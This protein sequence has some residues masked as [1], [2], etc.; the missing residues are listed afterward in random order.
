MTYFIY[1]QNQIGYSLKVIE[2]FNFNSS[3][4]MLTNY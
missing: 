4:Y 3:D 1:V 2:D